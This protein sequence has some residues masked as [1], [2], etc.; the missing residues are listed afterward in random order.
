MKVPDRS[1]VMLTHYGRRSGK[2]YRVKIWYTVIDGVVWLGSLDDDRNWVRNLRRSGKGSLDFGA[3]TIEF[4]CACA[5]EDQALR[6]YRDAVRAKYPILSR[7][8]EMLVRG[9]RPVA[10]RTDVGRDGTV[11]GTR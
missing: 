4:T 3:G 5:E 1:T 6:R 9:K 2:P 8:I 11:G 7:I 10:F